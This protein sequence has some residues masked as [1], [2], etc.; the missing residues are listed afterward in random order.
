M[1]EDNLAA[2]VGCHLGLVDFCELWGIIIF[3]YPLGPVGHVEGACQMAILQDKEMVI[4]KSPLI[5]SPPIIINLSRGTSLPTLQLLLLLKLY[6]N[7]LFYYTSLAHDLFLLSYC[8]KRSYSISPLYSLF[9]SAVCL[10]QYYIYS[11]MGDSSASYIHMV[12]IYL[13]VLMIYIYNIF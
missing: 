1:K 11:I 8:T 9:W 13:F 5:S 7:A 4:H 12:Y 10:F 3:S 6:N 2:M